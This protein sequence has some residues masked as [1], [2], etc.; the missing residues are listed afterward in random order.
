M[1]LGLT[2]ASIALTV[3][4][5][6][7]CLAVLAVGNLSTGPHFVEAILFP[8]PAMILIGGIIG[9]GT[10]IILPK[11]WWLVV[12]E[13]QLG[14]FSGLLAIGLLGEMLQNPPHGNL[15]S[16]AGYALLIC[17]GVLAGLS[18]ALIVRFVKGSR[19]AE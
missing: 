15:V 19:R 16:Y 5:S 18:P 3:L 4:P 2:L 7:L 10:G 6:F 17:C 1:L 12:L 9:W 13:T 8:I 11:M 14:W